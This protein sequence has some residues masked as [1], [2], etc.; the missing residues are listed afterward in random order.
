MTAE[1]INIDGMFPEWQPDTDRVFS[2]DAFISHKWRDPA[3]DELLEDL[4]LHGLEV[5]HDGHQNLADRR[6]L[7]KVSQALVHSR[8]LVVC[9]SSSFA[10]SVWCRAEY[11]SALNSG[12]RAHSHRDLSHERPNVYF[13]L[14]FARGLGKAVITIAREGTSIHFDVKDWTFIS[15]IDSRLLERD[16]K[17]RFQFELAGGQVAK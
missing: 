6:V 17:K 5:W 1:I 2:C 12:A 3:S 11:L 10:D 15:Y 13:E 9:C 16:L 7:Q 8:T 4:R 14:G